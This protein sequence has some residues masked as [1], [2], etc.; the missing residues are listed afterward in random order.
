MSHITFSGKPSNGTR[1]GVVSIGRNEG[2][3]LVRCLASLAP[4]ALPVVY[5]DSGSTD[6]SRASAAAA[7]ATVV[8]LDLSSPFTAARARSEGAEALL[9]LVP[10]LEFIQFV[11]GDCEIA[12]RWIGTARDFLDAQTDVAAAC[13]RRRERFAGAS[14][15]NRLCDIEWDTPIG[16]ASACGGD[17]LVRVAAYRA[18][19][20][21][22]PSMVAGEEPELCSRWRATGWRVW[23]LDAAMTTHDA[24]MTMLRQWWL[25]AVRSGFG[26]AQAW[27]VTRRR[28]PPLYGRELA[29]AAAW[30]ALP[31]ALGMAAAAAHPAGLLLT[32]AIYGLQIARLAWRDDA[33][34]RFA[35]QR[36]AL[37]TLAKP[38]EALGALRYV[39]R[40]RAGR[41]GATISYK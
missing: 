39:W 5:V 12:E 26:Y 40:A 3:R 4:L 21:F 25:R 37:L 35:W 38:A 36:A 27:A 2:E 20:G 8:T 7:G 41:S 23:R 14:V 34:R 28:K 6:G 18:V 1:V 16:E 9:R 29:R 22:D 32:P 11:D 17:A 33:R 19:G 13:G 24:D 30:T 10:G 31:P 15:Y